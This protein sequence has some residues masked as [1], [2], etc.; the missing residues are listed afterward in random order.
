MR[1]FEHEQDGRR[2]HVAVVGDDLALVIERALIS[3]SARS[4]AAITFVPPGWQMKRSISPVESFI[5][6]SISITAG[7]KCSANEIGNRALE[8][9]AK[10]LGIDAPAHDIERVGPQFFARCLDLRRAAVAGAQNDRRRAVA[11]QAGGDD[12]GLGQFIVAD[13]KRAEFERDQQHVGAG[14]RLRKARRDRQA[15][16]AARAAQTEDRHARHVGCESRACRRR[17][18]PASASRCRSNIP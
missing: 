3:D 8:D 4:S 13:R 18:P 10:S 16:H 9:D 7:P 15:R 1:A 2:R 6:A 17:A 12:I 5:R 11:E 14:P